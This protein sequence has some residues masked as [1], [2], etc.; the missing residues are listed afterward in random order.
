MTSTYYEANNEKKIFLIFL[1][2][3]IDEDE[4]LSSVGSSGGVRSVM[5]NFW[6]TTRMAGMVR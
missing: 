3:L 2:T 4:L 5:D 6:E 1:H